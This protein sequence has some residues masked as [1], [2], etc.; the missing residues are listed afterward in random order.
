[1]MGPVLYKRDNLFFRFAP[2]RLPEYY[3][4]AG[5][6]NQARLMQAAVTAI[7]N[8]HACQN[9]HPSAKSYESRSE[10]FCCRAHSSHVRVMVHIHTL[11][12]TKKNEYRVTAGLFSHLHQ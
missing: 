3:R 6:K 5:Q 11:R 12:Y 7:L 8:H 4:Y 2:G 1:M 10:S 9:G